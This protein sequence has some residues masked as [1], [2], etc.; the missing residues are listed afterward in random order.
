MRY[1]KVLTVLGICGICL[2]I[3]PYAHAQRFGVSVGVGPGYIGPPPVCTYGYYDYY[4]YECA[5]YG[6]YGPEWFDGGFFIGAG[7]WFHSFRGGFRGRGFDD[8]GRFFNGRDSRGGN[9]F[10]GQGNVRGNFQGG[11]NVRGGNQFR[12]GGSV[13]GNRGGG[14]VRSGGGFSGGGSFRGGGGG[15]GSRGGSSRGGGG[16]GGGRR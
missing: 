12:G 2:T 6:Y 1:L 14:N 11:G 8:R 4:P 7:P 16:H 9:E 15:G 10:R 5:P 13:Q 3:A